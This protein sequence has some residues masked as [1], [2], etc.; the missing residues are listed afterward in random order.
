M[1]GIIKQHVAL[2]GFYQGPECLLLMGLP[3]D[4]LQMSM[5]TDRDSCLQVSTLVASICN[6]KILAGPSQAGRE[7]HVS[8]YPVRG[9]L[10]PSSELESSKAP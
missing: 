3:I 1:P 5:C 9:Y 6:L 8:P 10:Y 7:Q 2:G 4:S